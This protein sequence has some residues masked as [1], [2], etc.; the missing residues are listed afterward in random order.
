MMR[1]MGLLYRRAELSDL[2]ILVV[3]RCAFL[4][5]ANGRTCD[6]ALVACIRQMLLKHMSHDTTV[7]WVAVVDDQVVATGSITFGERLPNMSA[8]DGRCAY[9]A[10]MYTRPVFRGQGIASCIFQHLLRESTARGISRLSLHALPAGAGIYRKAGFRYTD[11][12][13]TLAL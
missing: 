4:E 7:S 1:H 10:N 8:P 12:E 6:P 9:I 3:L 2:E 13:M 11:D 5:E